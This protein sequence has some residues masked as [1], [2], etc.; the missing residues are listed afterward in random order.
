LLNLGGIV[1]QS[2]PRVAFHYASPH[3]PLGRD[4]FGEVRGEALGSRRIARSS[5]ASVAEREFAAGRHG[6]KVRP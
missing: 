2:P 4:L 5:D 6:T 3:L 1:A